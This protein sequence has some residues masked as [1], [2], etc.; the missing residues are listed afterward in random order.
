MS[1]EVVEVKNNFWLKIA[2]S[3]LPAMLNEMG[4]NQEWFI[5]FQ[6]KRLM[7]AIIFL[8][9][10][11]VIGASVNA[12]IMLLGPILAVSV[13]LVEYQRVLNA[14]KRNQ[15]EK[16]LQFNKFTRLLNPLLRE[17][18]STLYKALNK[19][20]KRMDEGQVKTAL[21]RLLIG[22][23]DEPNS[24]APFRQFAKEASGTD[25]AMLYMT[26][27]FDYQQSSSD[28]TIINDLADMSSKQLFAGVREIIEFKLRKFAMFPTKLTMASFIPV[29]GYAAAM[30]IDT[31]SKVTN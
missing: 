24:E 20:L 5:K 29:M 3:N 10:G 9:L 13:W 31:I 23:S 18:N 27:L 17:V 4:Y 25:Q 22:L 26:T 14:Y 30:L 11:I 16:Q 12:W 19:M 21:K 15:F 1:E 28:P 7:L 2:E 8:G 6:K